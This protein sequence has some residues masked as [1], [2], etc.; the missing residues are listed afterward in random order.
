ML[1]YHAVSLL[2]F[3]P[4]IQHDTGLLFKA[5]TNYSK[6]VFLQYFVIILSV[7]IC[8]YFEH[9]GTNKT[10]SFS[11]SQCTHQGYVNITYLSDNSQM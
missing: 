3:L 4:L 11:A 6:T 5:L 10:F 7:Y 9:F 1:A 8:Q 2:T